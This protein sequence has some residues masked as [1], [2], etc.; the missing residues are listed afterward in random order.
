MWWTPHNDLTDR[1]VGSNR[2]PLNSDPNFIT[3]AEFDDLYA[4]TDYVGVI[5]TQ[6][7]LEVPVCGL[8]WVP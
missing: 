8:I 4:L 7:Q 5:D 3:Q 1:W 2:Y 6:Q